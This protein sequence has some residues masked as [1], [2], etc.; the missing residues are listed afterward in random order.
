M[1]SVFVLT[2]CTTLHPA[3]R[4]CETRTNGMYGPIHIC[5]LPMPSM[6]RDGWR[7]ESWHCEHTIRS[8]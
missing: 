7:V 1:L 2:I 8:N 5:P 3:E 4:D 6:V